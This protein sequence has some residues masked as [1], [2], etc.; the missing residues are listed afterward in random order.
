LDFQNQ[1]FR[2]KKAESLVFIRVFRENT[3]KFERQSRIKLENFSFR[4]FSGILPEEI[5]PFSI[6]K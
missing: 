5:I 6:S 1:A 3:G 2:N 4:L